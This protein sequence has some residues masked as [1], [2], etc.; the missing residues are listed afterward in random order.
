MKHLF[1]LA[2]LVCLSTNTLFSQSFQD[3]IEVYESSLE[4]L[5]SEKQKIKE[6]LNE[7]KISYINMQLKSVGLPLGAKQEE[8]A[9]HAGLILS[10]NENHELSNWVSSMILPD[11]EQGNFSRTNDFR[12]D[13]TISTGSAVEA[14]Y[15]LKTLISDN[16]FDYDGYGYDRG[17]LAPS[18]DYRWS[19]KAMSATYYYSNM[20]PQC[21]DF[22]RGKWAETEAF[23]RSYVMEN[24]TELMVYTGPILKDDL[25]KVE[26]SVNQ[27]SLPDYFY[28]IAIDTRNNR[29]IAFLM[30]NQMFED[31]IENYAVTIDSIEKLTGLDFLPK[32]DEKH[33][34]FLES[35][36]NAEPWFSGK[37]KGD[38]VA[39][40]KDEMPKYAFN[41]RDARAFMGTNKK[42]TV[43]GTVVSTHKS[44][45]GN[46]FL[47][48]D[49]S[50]PNQVFS[51]TIWESDHVNFSYEPSV[52]L[53]DKKVCVTGK[54]GEYQGI[55][56]MYLKHERNIQLLD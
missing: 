28:K 9:E 5:E 16:K 50:F 14:D 27:M 43:C 31:P 13:T 39:L 42:I 36:C 2:S 24:K 22:N 19:Q 54:V 55:P 29:A 40:S 12:P 8:I 26:R 49:K 37:Q 47:N 7:F 45:K 30:P 23:L 10:Y 11:I 25:P 51:V 32:L 33:Q 21:P 20:S 15:F 56:S 44:R 48:L 18:A 6:Q 52:F 3:S 46:T 17:H 41:T 1:L 38:R 35:N 53:K 34:V 4:K